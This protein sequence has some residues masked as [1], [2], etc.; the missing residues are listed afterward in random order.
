[1]RVIDLDD[2]DERAK[3]G[4][5]ERHRPTCQVL[6]HCAAKALDQSGI[7][8]DVRNPLGHRRIKRRLGAAAVSLE[9]VE[10]ILQA[11]VEVRRPPASASNR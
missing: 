10:P 6:A 1:M 8:A 3:V 7:D 11:L 9:A 4:L 5:P 2:V